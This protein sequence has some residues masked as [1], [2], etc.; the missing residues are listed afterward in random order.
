ALCISQPAL[1]NQIK[2]LEDELGTKL[3]N[4]VGYDHKRL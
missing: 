3:F 2:Q 1:S 4:R